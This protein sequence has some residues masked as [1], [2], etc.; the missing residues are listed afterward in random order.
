MTKPMSVERVK[1]TEKQRQILRHMAKEPGDGHLRA[2]WIAEGCGHFYDTIWA[3]SALPALAKRGLVEKLGVPG[4]WVI[5]TAGRAA[6]AGEQ[7]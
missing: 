7:P 1:L 5:T 6:L 4:W 3:S 2:E